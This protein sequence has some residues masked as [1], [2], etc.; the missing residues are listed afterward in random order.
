MLGLLLT[1]LARCFDFMSITTLQL[2]L[3]LQ[4]S[5]H[6]WAPGPQ[7]SSA[8]FLSGYQGLS[9]ARSSRA[10][11]KNASAFST[12][13][14]TPEMSKLDVVGC[15]FFFK[16]TLVIFNLLGTQLVQGSKKLCFLRL[17]P[18]SKAQI[19]LPLHPPQTSLGFPLLIS[20]MNSS[21]RYGNP[22]SIIDQLWCSPSNPP[23]TTQ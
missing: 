11:L 23:P 13:C 10:P 5:P 16:Y 3:N 2:L 20:A 1:P 19:H 12:F 9:E 14:I 22:F 17:L 7:R 21:R 8:S 18:R 15:P 4:A 6:L